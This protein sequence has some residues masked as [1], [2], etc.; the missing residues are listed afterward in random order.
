MKYTYD[1]EPAAY[2]TAGTVGKPGQRTFYIQARRGRE[3]VAFLTEKEQV[4]ALG[5][6]LDRLG[7]EIVS[8]N[9]LLSP[10]DDD[11][12]IRDMSLIE[13]IEPAFRVAQLGLGYDAERDL[14]VII[15]QGISDDEDEESPSARICIP[16]DQMRGLSKHIVQLVAG[17]RKICGNCGRPQDPEGHFCPQMN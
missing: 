2:L 6:A 3:L 11:L 14:C 8:N 17:G 9:A 15:M 13:P 5:I 10:K 1:F 4:R 16:R 12:L 7:E